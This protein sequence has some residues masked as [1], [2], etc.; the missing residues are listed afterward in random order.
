MDRYGIALAGVGTPNPDVKLIAIAR[1]DGGPWIEPTMDTVLNRSYP[2]AR[3]VWI[4]VNRAPGL[5]LEPKVR[6]FLRYILS[7]EGQQDVARE[8]EYLPLTAS[9]ARAEARKLE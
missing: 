1:S 8:G 6:E 4:Y 9:L 3:S 5:P 2:F 7:R